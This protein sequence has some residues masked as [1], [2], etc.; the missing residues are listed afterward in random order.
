[1][2]LMLQQELP[3]DYVIA[4]GENHS[5]KE[6]CAYAF[7]LVGLHWEE[8]VKS[9]PSLL[10][11]KEIA[12]LRGNSA[13]ARAVLGWQPKTTFHEMIQ[14]MLAADLEKLGVGERLV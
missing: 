10:R 3:G 12:D 5:V 4:T 7:S 8:H 1:M 14:M 2:Y 9:E 11:P 6:L 13:K